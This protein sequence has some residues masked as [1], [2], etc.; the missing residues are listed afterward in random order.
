MKLIDKSVLTTELEN[1]IKRAAERWK[2]PEGLITATGRGILEGYN[3]I[4]SFINTLET[5]EVNLEESLSKLDKDIK[6]FVTTEEFEKESKTCGH[7][8]AIAKHAFLLGIKAQNE[9]IEPIPL[10]T[11]FFFKNGYHTTPVYDVDDESII[12]THIN[13]L[14]EWSWYN[15]KIYYSITDEEV[16]EMFECKYVHEF[17]RFLRLIGSKKRSCCD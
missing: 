4:L 1:R 7:Y 10:T 16:I 12:Y 11:E 17:Q 8:W 3:S 15:G 2:T 5:K 9:N 13:L 6:E 14:G